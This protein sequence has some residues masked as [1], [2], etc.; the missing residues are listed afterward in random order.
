M[1]VVFSIDLIRTLFF[2]VRGELASFRGLKLSTVFKMRP[3]VLGRVRISMESV[4]RV[5]STSRASLFE[6]RVSH[7]KGAVQLSDIPAVLLEYREHLVQEAGALSL[8]EPW[9]K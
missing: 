2:G 8:K 3:E 7:C 5:A 6:L 1:R 4:L 9:I